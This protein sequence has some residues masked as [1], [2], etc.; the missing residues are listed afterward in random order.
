M[1]TRPFAI[2]TLLALLAG[3]AAC[4]DDGPAPPV[5]G[6]RAAD[7]TPIPVLATVYPLADLARAVGGRHVDVLWW[8]ESGQTL[9]GYEPSREQLERMFKAGVV[10]SG[11]TGEDFVTRYF[12]DGVNDRRIVRL[13]A[14]AP[15]EA[16]GARQQWLDLRVARAALDATAA[17]LAVIRPEARP[18]FEAN[19]AAAGRQVDALVDDWE[20]RLSALAGRTLA[21]VGRDYT[22]LGRIAGFTVVSVS[23]A[24]AVQLDPERAAAVRKAV[25]EARALMLLVEADTPPAVLKS[26]QAQMPVPVVPIDSM[27]SSS[28]AGRN[29]YEKVMRYN[30]QQ[31]YDGWRRAMSG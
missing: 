2:L 31:L 30:L 6:N 17:Q 13:D 12:S 18:D 3:A 9:N 23:D 25:T 5:R 14:F 26:L 24:S 7:P 8:V 4:D 10:L 19:A 11:G 28:S 22:P 27:G 15:L 21:S 29:T 1:L 20:T 16:R